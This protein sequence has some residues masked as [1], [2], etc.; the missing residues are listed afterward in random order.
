VVPTGTP[1]AAAISGSATRIH[2]RW[3][4]GSERDH[5]AALRD[6]HSRVPI[7]ATN[8]AEAAVSFGRNPLEAGPLIQAPAASSSDWVHRVIVR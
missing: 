2:P 6:G 7:L 1:A 5:A 4:C 8:P 3:D